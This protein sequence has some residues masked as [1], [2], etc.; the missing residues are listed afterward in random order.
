MAPF[1]QCA[2]FLPSSR[3]RD[4]FFVPKPF[5][6]HATRAS[7]VS[8]YVFPFRSPYA[9]LNCPPGYVPCWQPAIILLPCRNLPV[10]QMAPLF[11]AIHNNNAFRIKNSV[12]F[13]VAGPMENFPSPHRPIAAGHTLGKNHTCEQV[14]SQFMWPTAFFTPNFWPRYFDPNNLVRQLNAAML[15]WR[16][17]TLPHKKHSP[18]PSKPDAKVFQRRNSPV[19]RSGGFERNGSL[20]FPPPRPLFTSPGTPE[21]G[22]FLGPGHAW[23]RM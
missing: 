1:C 21:A 6:F 19:L 20:M 8:P 9:R 14:E 22:I 15:S 12:L 10:F 4:F 5:F 2:E 17:L 23:M 13:E 11:P 16:L 7:G 18:F 3:D